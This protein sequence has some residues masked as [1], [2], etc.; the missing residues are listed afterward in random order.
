MFSV[1]TI[2]QIVDGELLRGENTR[3]A[4]AVHHSRLIEP[5]DLF[6][7]LP[8]RSSDGH[9]FLS[10]AFNRGA[11]AALVSDVG[12]LPDQAR[13]IIRVPDTTQALHQWASAWREQTH[14][15]VVAITGTNGKT[16]VRSLLGHLLGSPEQVNIYVSPHNYNTE[17]GL[18]LA[19]LSMPADT[20]LGVFELGTERP[21]DIATLARIIAPH[22]AI[23]TTVGPGHLDGLGTLDAVAEEKWSLAKS[24]PDDGV[25]I[26]N[27]DDPRLVERAAGS[28]VRIIAPGIAN[29]SPQAQ[30]IQTVPFLKLALKDVGMHLEC[31]LVGTH[32]AVNLLMAAVAAR[33]LGI[34]WETI[35]Q[36][37]ATFQPVPHRLHPIQTPF[38]TILDDTYN[39]NPASV[40]AALEVLASYPPHTSPRLFVFGEMLELGDQSEKFHH[41]VVQLALQLSIGAILPI[42]D[43]AIAA[44]RDVAEPKDSHRII[45]LPREEVGQWI[46][47]Q[48]TSLIVLVKGSRGL[49]LE[50]L[51]S[52]LLDSRPTEI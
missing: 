52:E 2:A 9:T 39:A 29:G 35:A 46:L 31:P 30:I 13:N 10:D 25:V 26:L 11:C 1:E 41:D 45:V 33:E 17:I 3:P 38:G 21:G 23:L 27:A 7:A 18:P 44:C 51:V 8:G 22:L 48:G 47:R 12:H 34:E 50:N 5:G 14:P 4:R 28:A 43:A 6:V 20:A 19:L 15:F 16:T 24:L 42:G 49:A 40:K 32:N 36:R 37:A